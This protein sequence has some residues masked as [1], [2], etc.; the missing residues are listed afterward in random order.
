MVFV[1]GLF[2][3]VVSGGWSWFLVSGWNIGFYH[4]L[5]WRVVG[6]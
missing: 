2:L 6:F 5:W 3:D 4:V 1:A